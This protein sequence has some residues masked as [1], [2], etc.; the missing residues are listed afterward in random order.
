MQILKP[1]SSHQQQDMCVN[2]GL[3]F[4]LQ[5]AILLNNRKRVWVA[6]IV[7]LKTIS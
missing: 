2:Q 3:G 5:M 7:Q 1:L 6:K 4:V